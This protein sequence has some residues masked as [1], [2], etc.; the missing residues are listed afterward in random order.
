MHAVSWTTKQSKKKPKKKLKQKL[1]SVLDAGCGAHMTELERQGKREREIESE[2][3]KK[4]SRNDM[5]L[6]KQISI[7]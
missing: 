1:F 5:A 2:Q 6:A 4:N 3:K 7:K